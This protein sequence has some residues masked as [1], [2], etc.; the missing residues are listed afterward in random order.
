VQ[1]VTPM[2]GKWV[3][4]RVGDQ[5][6]DLVGG[7]FDEGFRGLGSGSALAVQSDD[8]VKD[9]QLER[10]GRRFARPS[11]PFLLGAVGLAVVGVVLIIVGSSG[12][13]ALGIVLA[14]LA[15]IPAVVGL[16]LLIVAAVSRWAARD[17]PFA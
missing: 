8:P 10:Q 1:A 12:V 5:R 4:D 14:A 15:G 2:A 9:P 11:L 6:G 16:A 13:R 3:L 7:R 17:R